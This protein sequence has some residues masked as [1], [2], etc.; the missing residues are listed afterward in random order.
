VLEA[1]PALELIDQMPADEHAATLNLSAVPLRSLLQEMKRRDWQPLPEGAFERIVGELEARAEKAEAAL[2]G[3]LA[4]AAERQSRLVDATAE[5]RELGRL[6]GVEL[7]KTAKYAM[8]LL[9]ENTEL[10]SRVDRAEADAT[11]L[12]HALIG[13]EV[14]ELETNPDND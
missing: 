11:R 8:E 6:A 9:D 3:V 4:A 14:A 5:V 13:G 1:D 2:A 10:R 12:A 7:P